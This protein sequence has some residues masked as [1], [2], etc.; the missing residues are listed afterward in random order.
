MRSTR[1]RLVFPLMLLLSCAK[2]G[3]PPGG[4]VDKD[5]PA[6]VATEP[7]ADAIEVGLDE[8]IVLEFSESMDGRRT[9]AAVFVSPRTQVRMGWRGRRLEIRPT[10]GL[11]EEQTYVITVGTDARDLRGN[12]LDQS[13]TFAFATGKQLNRGSITGRVLSAGRAAASAN[14][15]AYHMSRALAGQPGVDPPAYETQSGR[16]GAYEFRRLAPGVY[17]IIAFD[18]KDDDGTYETE[19]LLALSSGDATLV[20][21]DEIHFGDL[22]L[23]RHGEA[24]VARLERVQALDDRVVMLSFA[25]PVEESQEIDVA[26]EGLSIEGQHRSTSD[27]TRWYLLTSLQ[28]AG[29]AYELST[30]KVDG[31]PVHWPE[32][33]RGSNRADRRAPALESSFPVGELAASVEAVRLSFS[34]AMD[35]AYPNPGE[36]LWVRSDSTASPQGM[37]KWETPAR[38]VFALSP[39]LGPGDYQ[40]QASL[41][42]L[43]ERA[44]LALAD[45]SVTLAFEVLSKADLSSISGTV[46]ND[47]DSSSV[48]ARV[49][50]REAGQPGVI[51]FVTSDGV[52][53][54]YMIEGLAPGQYEVHCIDD[55]D[56]DGIADRGSLK[57]YEPAERHQSYEHTISLSR[58]EQMVNIDFRLKL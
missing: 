15:W 9:S 2:V 3:R 48:A 40:L 20:E 49:E 25:E 26:I 42:G 36:D 14:V 43:R 5:A 7:R 55:V 47:A 18:D 53:G 56:D 41:A 10:A 30:M 31:R 44:G 8:S 19:E 34:E 1:L 24:A 46:I 12:K 54:H 35:S 11:R 27:P 51:N 13:F 57:P 37:W 50:V 22:N 52:D 28:E 21:G 38:L 23:V 32:P 45:S 6:I 29:T 39:P 4:A 17:R 16:D 33:V 58:A